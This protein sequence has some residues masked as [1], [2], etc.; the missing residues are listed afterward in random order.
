MN[1][2]HLTANLQLY[3]FCSGTHPTRT[4]MVMM[5][6]ICA[7]VARAA[8]T[9]SGFKQRPNLRKELI[10]IRWRRT[11]R[12]NAELKTWRGII[13]EVVAKFPDAINLDVRMN[14]Y[15]FVKK[16]QDDGE[17]ISSQRTLRRKDYCE[18]SIRFKIW[19]EFG[20]SNRQRLWL[21][22]LVWQ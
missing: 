12:N 8:R 6:M 10:Q 17:R 15:E 3:W 7:G 21:G 4:L 18:Q 14:E 2:G 1:P 11:R 16:M 5:M 9:H 13:V 19:N 20:Q 22:A